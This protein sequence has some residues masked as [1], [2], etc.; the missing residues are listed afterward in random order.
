MKIDK[1]KLIAYGPFTDLELDFAGSGADFHMVYGPNEAGKSSALRALR[2]MLFGIPVRTSDGFLHPNPH[3]RIGARLIRSD[4]QAISFVRRKGQKNT[5]RGPDGLMLLDD[6]SLASFLGGVDRDLF[7]QMFA[8]GHEDL[9]KGGEEIISGGGSVGQALFAA[10]AG[11]IRLQS[12]RQSLEQTCEGLFKPGGLKPRINASVSALKEA[13]KHQKEALLPARTWHVHHKS[14]QN[15]EQRLEIVRHRLSQLKQESVRLERIQKALPVIARKKEIDIERLAYEGVPILSE[16]FGE[17][18]RKIENELKIAA[19]D[20]KRVQEAICGIRKQMDTLSIPEELTRH[21]ELIEILQQDLG[22]YRSAQKDRPDRV[23]RM[24]TLKKQASDILSEIG[25]GALFNAGKDLKLPPAVIG[26]IQELVKTFDRL[27]TRLDAAW[28][29]HRKLE[30][31]IHTLMDQKKA[32]PAPS[33]VT[34]LKVVLQTVQDVGPIEKRLSETL[35]AIEHRENALKKALKRMPLWSGSLEDLDTL[36]CPSRESVD[37]FEVRLTESMR[38]IEKLKAEIRNVE[39]EK[40][41]IETE[42]N[43]IERFRDVPT[44]TDLLQARSIRENGWRL[45]RAELEG[46]T[47]LSSDVDAFTGRFENADLSDAFEKSVEQAD[48]IADR[49]RREAEEVGRKGMLE[50]GKRQCERKNEALDNSL[51][52]ALAAYAE[53]DQEWI[54]LWEPVRIRPLFPKEMHAWLSDIQTIREKLADIG[55]ERAKAA[56]MASERDLL[57]S[58]L[59]HALGE[60]INYDHQD[61]SLAKL[62]GIAKTYVESQQ[63]L[64]SRAESIERDLLSHRKEK[65]EIETTI[66]GLKTQLRDW[67]TDWG[68]NVEKINLDAD[69]GPTAAMVVIDS[70]REAKVLLDEADVLKKRVDGIDRDA[71]VFQK[72]VLHLVNR[73][74]PDLSGEPPDRAALLLNA[75]LTEAR[76]SL[77]KQQSLEQQLTDA[78]KERLLAEKRIADATTLIHSLCREAHCERPEDLEAIEKRSRTRQQKIKAREDLENRLRDFGAGATVDAFIAEAESVRPDSID[79]ELER[80]AENIKALELERSHLD[81]TIGTEKAELTRMDGGAEAAAHAEEAERL[82]ASLESDVETY[83]RFK[84]AAVILSRTIE[85]YREKHQGPLIDRASGLF[86]QMTLGSFI[87]VRA[88]YDETGSPILVGLRPG[89]DRQLTVAGMS[90]GTADQLYLSLRLAGLEQYLAENEPLP[91]VVDDILLRFDDERAAATLTVLAELSQK[92]Q[93]IFFTHHSHLKK[94]ADAYI[95]PSKLVHHTL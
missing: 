92:T 48:H 89:G 65:K 29:Q 28:E 8:I 24:R 33:D 59:V 74:A 55:S 30:T 78:E 50:A 86:S 94:L 69:V 70:I 93:V 38:E 83:A 15:A 67:K 47:L 79:S 41:Q 43:A 81:Q 2:S 52:T 49:L 73:L 32:L 91:F 40:M 20:F 27:N 90:D 6:A 64:Q 76:E 62:I 56:G 23:G 75:R 44:E 10:G 46:I 82:L 34:D 5:L 14:L 63:A 21:A 12:F 19:N 37:R 1:M 95:D 25:T 77:S 61:A 88:E 54:R 72:Q 39:Q 84:I 11:L 45:I 22:K 13:R 60:T 71:D 57:K 26:E 9:V 7:E 66:T 3:L 53:L 17:K 85:Q 16:E 36:P 80:L 42:L 68:K 87:G 31:R 35:S 58:Q 4:G 18:R 51:K